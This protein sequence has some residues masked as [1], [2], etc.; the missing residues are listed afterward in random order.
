M[1]RYLPPDWPIL[2]PFVECPGIGVIPADFF[3]NYP[4]QAAD[5][6]RHH[7]A[8]MK[9][10]F[11]FAVAKKNRRAGGGSGN[12]PPARHSLSEAS[13]FRSVG[14]AFPLCPFMVKVVEPRVSRCF[15]SLN[16]LP[17][18]YRTTNPSSLY[19]PRHTSRS[20]LAF[21]IR[22]RQANAAYL[23][24][25]ACQTREEKI[26]VCRSARLA[27]LSARAKDRAE[28]LPKKNF[29]GRTAN[30]SAAVSG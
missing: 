17:R 30:G 5:T 14:G 23:M 8:I 21:P 4:S 27:P 26:V 29:G 3:Q 22:L 11:N 20:V 13:G 9:H 19:R 2:C 15:V 10:M 16:A 12:Q 18:P 1:A 28:R 25:T 24:L 7:C 6:L